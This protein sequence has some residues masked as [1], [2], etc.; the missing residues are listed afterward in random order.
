[1]NHHTWTD[2]DDD[3]DDNG[4]GQVGLLRLDGQTDELTTRQKSGPAT[5]LR[6]TLDK[7]GD[8]SLYQVGARLF[9]HNNRKGEEQTFF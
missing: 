1:M 9:R 3:D 8:R 6:C 4:R 7:E 2:G 5:F